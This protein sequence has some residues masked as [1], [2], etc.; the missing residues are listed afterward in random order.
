MYS[1]T[2]PASSK[3]LF[4]WDQHHAGSG[5]L[6]E[7]RRLS[8]KSWQRKALRYA[9]CNYTVYIPC[10]HL[11]RVL[12]SINC[13]KDHKQSWVFFWR[14]LVACFKGIIMT[15]EFI[16]FL[17]RFLMNEPLDV[18]CWTLLTDWEQIILTQGRIPIMYLLA[19]LR[20]PQILRK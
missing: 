4:N 6:K 8:S 1:G 18:S 19:T 15:I 20:L 7:P 16:A 3:M 14:N 10:S 12:A 13:R 5:K 2:T 11:S 9:L 17:L